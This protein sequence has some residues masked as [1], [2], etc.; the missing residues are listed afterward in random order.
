MLGL[1]IKIVGEENKDLIKGLKKV[2][3]E[4]KNGSDNMFLPL[5]DGKGTECDFSTC[6]LGELTLYDNWGK[7]PPV[8]FD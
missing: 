5:N 7:C 8:W 3:E 1:E 2:L 4:L 6:R